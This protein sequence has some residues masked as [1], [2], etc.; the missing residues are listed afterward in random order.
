MNGSRSLDPREPE[1]VL[2][3][4]YRIV[5]RL[6]R[7]GLGAVFLCEDLRLPSRMWAIKQ[8]HVPDPGMQEHFRETFERE[9]AILARIR[10]P[11][12]PLVVDFFE[13]N[14]CVYLVMEYVQ[15]ENLADH[16]RRV[17]RLPEADAFAYGLMIADLL[18]FLHGQRP[19]LIFRDLKP[20]NVMLSP[21]RTVK[22]VDFGLARRFVPG[23]RSGDAL[24]SGSVGY[25]APE[26]WGET[27]QPDERSDVYSWGATMVYLLCGKVPSPVFPLAPLRDLEPSLTEAGRTILARCVKA[28]PSDRYADAATLSRDVERH[29]DCVREPGGGE[30]VAPP[31]VC[32]IERSSAPASDAER[33]ALQDGSQRPHAGDAPGSRAVP[34]ALPAPLSSDALARHAGDAIARH[35]SREPTLRVR[36]SCVGE[37]QE[38]R[39]GGSGVGYPLVLLL[40]ATFAFLGAL[41]PRS[42]PRCE[43][44]SGNLAARSSAAPS[45]PEPAMLSGSVARMATEDRR[46]GERDYRAGRYAEAIAAL[47]RATTANPADA[48]AQILYADS[49]VRITGEPSM[50]IS[51]IASLTGVNASDGRARLY[52]L[53][54]AQSLANRPGHRRGRG[55][56]VD[57]YDDGSSDAK[58]LAIATRLLAE[59]TSPG[60]PSIPVSGAPVSGGAPVV[61]GTPLPVVLLGACSRHRVRLLAPLFNAAHVNLVAQVASARGFGAS[62]GPCVFLLSDAS[63]EACLALARHL[64][65]KKVGSVA[66]VADAALPELQGPL[67][68][69]ASALRSGRVTVVRV[70]FLDGA[71][72]DFSSQVCAIREVHPD[73]VFLAEYSAPA[74]ARFM[75]VL[76]G[77]GVTVP[78]CAMAVPFA[79]DLVK[80]GGSAVEGLLMPGEFLLSA[81]TPAT[82]AFRVA[83]RHRFGSVAPTALA[84]RTFD[85]F[86]AVLD[87]LEKTSKASPAGRARALNTFFHASGVTAPPFDGIAGRI[88]L[89]TRLR[90]RKLR[91]YRIEQGR[92]RPVD[93]AP[94]DFPQAGAPV[95][96]FT[97]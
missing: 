31:I 29:L 77:A 4:R 95:G 70:P 38:A 53:A 6:G 78:V 44:N 61:G 23:K 82:R 10:H 66:V 67:R 74:I 57:V 69:F 63:E 54:L 56:V 24:P 46:R 83:F 14:D 93:D 48:L 12:L 19:P 37:S 20:E 72:C 5:R 25:A 59:G 84:V 94:R 52:G 62:A 68:V 91:L 75:R 86:N 11:N 87:G 47:D 43:E 16:V 39:G 8:M 80:H 85:V 36:K 1:R 64:V 2:L 55:V 17:G 88:A 3:Q 21:E 7:G 32:E 90:V 49:A 89:G 51:L 45:A 22:L 34:S 71:R 81:S 97:R 28:R 76:R 13:E 42:T 60:A 65:C 58:C 96:R 79:A 27:V 50:R 73:A 18:V 33:E 26:Q 92:F 41:L 35:P 40:V 15:G 9:A 30:D